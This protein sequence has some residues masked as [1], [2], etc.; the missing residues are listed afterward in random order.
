VVEVDDE[1]DVDLERLRFFEGVE[2]A[3]RESR[4]SIYSCSWN[5]QRSSID[6]SSGSTILL[7]ESHRGGEGTS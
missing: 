4:N 6:A 2:S 7:S 1:D 5:V 3:G